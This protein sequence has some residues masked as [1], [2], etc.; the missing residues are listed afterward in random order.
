MTIGLQP[1]AAHRF[2]RAVNEAGPA[3]PSS[4]IPRMSSTCRPDGSQFCVHCRGEPDRSVRRRPENSTLPSPSIGSTLTRLSTPVVRSSWTGLRSFVRTGVVIGF[5]PVARILLVGRPRR[6]W[7]SNRPVRPG[8]WLQPSSTTVTPP[9]H[10]SN[11]AWTSRPFRQRGF[12]FSPDIADCARFPPTDREAGRGQSVPE[13]L[14]IVSAEQRALRLPLRWHTTAT[15]SCQSSR[16]NHPQTHKEPPD[17][18][19][20]CCPWQTP[21]RWSPT[22]CG[23]RAGPGHAPWPASESPALIRNNEH[24]W[25][26]TTMID[27]S[28][29]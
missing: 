14:V 28:L 5:D 2:H 4:A 7:N 1:D 22:R 10:F 8:S 19:A 11:L 16:G 23:R 26:T 27:P 9:T 17:R 6:N 21:R 24:R 25:R 18:P 15:N 13:I 20:G 29:S 12:R 3:G